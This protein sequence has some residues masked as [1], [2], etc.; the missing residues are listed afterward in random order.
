MFVTHTGDLVFKG[1]IALMEDVN[2][3]ARQS[4]VGDKPV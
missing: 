2:E 1:L 4:C 3:M